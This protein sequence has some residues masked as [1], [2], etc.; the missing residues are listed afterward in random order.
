M[1]RVGGPLMSLSASGTIADTLTYSGWKGIPYVR[2]R[3]IP[4]NPRSTEQTKTRTAFTYLQDLYKF[5]P[6]IGREPWIA[7]TVGIP[8]TPQ[9]LLLSKNVGNLRDEL[10]LN[11]LIMSPGARGGIPPSS[12]ISTPSTDTITVAVTAPT[13]PAGW[14][15]TAAQGLVVMDQD[16]H[17]ALAGSPV[18]AEDTTS[19]YSLVF[20]P[21]IT[22]ELY[23]IG[24][25]LKWLT[26]TGQAAYSI[27]LRDTDTPT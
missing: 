24:V 14:T 21:L 15:I 20:T 27:A 22:G 6:G 11:L 19:T 17:I 16:P 25:W 3:V 1:A 2:T 12:I 13:G 4:A 8:M 10:D 5:L 7:A 23:Q 9:N 18:A 26:P